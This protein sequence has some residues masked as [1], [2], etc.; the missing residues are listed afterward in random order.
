MQTFS[1][2]RRSRF[3]LQPLLA[4][5]LFGAAMVYE[6]VGTV[7]IWLTP[8]LGVGFYLW[9]RYRT[10]KRYYFPITLFFLY[11]LYF[12]IDRDMILFSFILLALLYHYFLAEKIEH[13]MNC[14]FCI[15][16]IY[17]LYAYLGY[18]LI[19]LFLAFLFNLP[20]PEFTPLYFIYI[21]TDLFI[22]VLLS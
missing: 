1:Y 7:Y 22:L 16:L 5:L 20:L 14:I 10:Q 15:D 17:V 12:E 2:L 6:A 18:Y 3:N 4:L 13:T 8:L 21:V 11:T 19:N 9:R